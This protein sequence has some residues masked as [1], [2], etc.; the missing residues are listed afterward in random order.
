MRYRRIEYFF[1][2]LLHVIILILSINEMS[3]FRIFLLLL[4]FL[5]SGW[6]L[7]CCI[8][9]LFLGGTMWWLKTFNVLNF[10]GFK[11]LGYYI[12]EHC[13]KHLI[14]LNLYFSVFIMLFL[15][16]KCLRLVTVNNVD[17]K[18]AN[19][20]EWFVPWKKS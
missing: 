4:G 7:D 10:H 20:K 19:S 2:Y 13:T 16:I 15:L 5:I 11:H 8:L 12:P 18:L 3:F 6:W 9:F 14:L 17:G 1:G